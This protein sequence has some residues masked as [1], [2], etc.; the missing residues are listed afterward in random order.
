VLTASS[1]LSK[2]AEQLSG[3]VNSFVAGVRAA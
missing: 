2:R 1:D 3:E